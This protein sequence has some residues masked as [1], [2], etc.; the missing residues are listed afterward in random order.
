[1]N[2][3]ADLLQNPPGTIWPLAMLLFMLVMLHQT[4]ERLEPVITAVVAGL[5]KDAQRKYYLYAYAG[6][7][8]TAA[9]LQQL[10]KVAEGMGW[11]YTAAMAE[12]AQP[13][14]VTLIALLPRPVFANPEPTVT[15]P[16]VPQ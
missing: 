16:P 15:R 2:T 4:R 7:I 1:M 10:G 14:F 5:A 8:C 3:L 6:L 9:S 13:A 11:R 12:V